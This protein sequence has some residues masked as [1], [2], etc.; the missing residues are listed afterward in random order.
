MPDWLTYTL[1]A[2]GVALLA[3][4]VILAR[5]RVFTR[6]RVAKLL[7]TFADQ[8]RRLELDFL[9]QAAKLGKPRGLRWLQADWQPDVFLAWDRTQDGYFAL[10]EAAFQFEA[11]P[12]SDMIDLPAVALA[13]AGTALFAWTGRHWVPTGRVFF[14]L[15][16]RELLTHRAAQFQTLHPLEPMPSRS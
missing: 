1:V 12:D 16:P 2:A 9:L 7:D 4:A 13:K 3:L 14:N 11:E 6:W 15:S 5:G 10:V 8:R